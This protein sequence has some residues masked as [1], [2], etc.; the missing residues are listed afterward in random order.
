MLLTAILAELFST[1]GVAVLVGGWD[2]SLLA[3]RRRA[4]YSLRFG[5]FPSIGVV[6]GLLGTGR[7]DD[8]LW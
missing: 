5:L 8:V 3:A 2:L 4:M 7:E 1:I 6:F